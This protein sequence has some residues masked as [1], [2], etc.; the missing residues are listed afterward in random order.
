MKKFIFGLSLTIAF[1]AV[2]FTL[3]PLS[4]FIACWLVVYLWWIYILKK[5]KGLALYFLVLLAVLIS[6]LSVKVYLREKRGLIK[7][8]APYAFYD[9]G[10]FIEI[11]GGWNVSDT[12]FESTTIICDKRLDICADYTARLVMGHLH[13]APML[14]KIKYWEGEAV[15]PDDF[16]KEYTGIIIGTSADRGGIYSNSLL[17]IDRKNKSVFIV[18]KKSG[19]S[20]D[21]KELIDIKNINDLP[22]DWEIVE[23][24]QNTFYQRY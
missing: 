14:W 6:A 18:K 11:K 9:L 21:W 8:V 13:V 10:D 1:L 24:L 2:F 20:D 3:D 15:N 4:I 23:K 19:N 16:L 12:K 22:D 5:K 17:Y 7:S